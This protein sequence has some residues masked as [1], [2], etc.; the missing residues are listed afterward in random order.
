VLLEKA[1]QKVP[2]ARAATYG[3]MSAAT[4]TRC[5]RE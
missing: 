5:A 3:F 2:Q 4:D 1:A